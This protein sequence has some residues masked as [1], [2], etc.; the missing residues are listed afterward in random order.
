MGE[1]HGHDFVDIVDFVDWDMIYYQ[2]LFSYPFCYYRAN[3]GVGLSKQ[4]SLPRR[5]A[6]KENKFAVQPR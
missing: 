6:G 3:A 1:C 4:D 2:S 5:D